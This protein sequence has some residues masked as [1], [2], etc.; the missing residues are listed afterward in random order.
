MNRLKFFIRE[1]KNLKRELR[2]RYLMY[3]R[4]EYVKRQMARRG[5]GCGHHGCCGLSFFAR[6]RKCLAP[7]GKTCLR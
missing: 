5:G 1:V 7:D 4:P 6:F 3:F 2:A